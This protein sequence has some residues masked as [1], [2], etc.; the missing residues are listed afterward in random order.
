MLDIVYGRS[1]VT[2]D[3][4]D[5]THC[6]AWYVTLF[7]FHVINILVELTMFDKIMSEAQACLWRWGSFINILRIFAGVWQGR[8]DGYSEW[9]FDSVERVFLS[10]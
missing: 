3:A 7:M 5:L 4:R 1:R 9:G 6:C 2:T 10:A 8:R